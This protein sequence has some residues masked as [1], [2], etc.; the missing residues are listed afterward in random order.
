MPDTGGRACESCK[1]VRIPL[2]AH[3]QVRW[4]V[5]RSV[6]RRDTTG[7]EGGA[8]AD[9][10]AAGATSRQVA[11]CDA[12]CHCAVGPTNSWAE[13]DGRYRP[14]V[15]WILPP[16]SLVGFWLTWGRQH[17]QALRRARAEAAQRP[18][19]RTAGCGRPHALLCRWIAIRVE[20]AVGRPCKQVGDK[21]GGGVSRG[22][23]SPTSASATLLLSLLLLLLLLLDPPSPLLPQSNS[24][25]PLPQPS[26]CSTSHTVARVD[27]GATIPG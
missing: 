15:Y 8:L 4:P 25:P 10:D 14:D 27:S 24:T 16:P 6:V 9:R 19:G 23:P 11:R 5:G 26:S 2:P 13:S 18:R 17:T 7:A 22:A 3:V 21:K 1:F 20:K 12:A